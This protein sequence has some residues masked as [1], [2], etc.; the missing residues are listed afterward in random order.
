MK[1][2]IFGA[3]GRMGRT[4]IQVSD[5]I[6]LAEITAAV[7][8]DGSKNRARYRRSFRRGQNGGSYHFQS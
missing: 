6:P 8:S 3:T 7:A 4:L 2:G 1:I 5:D